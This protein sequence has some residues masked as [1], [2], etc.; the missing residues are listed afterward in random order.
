[1]SGD[2]QCVA[3][4]LREGSISVYQLLLGEGPAFSGGW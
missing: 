4:S 2:S 1:M 3:E